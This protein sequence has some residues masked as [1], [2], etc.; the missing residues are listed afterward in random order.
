M[1]KRVSHDQISGIYAKEY[2]PGSGILHAAFMC[3]KRMLSILEPHDTRIARDL[4]EYVHTLD[5]MALK[6]T[7]QQY[8][9]LHPFEYNK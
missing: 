5:R 7:I 4:K 3:P 1:K 9:A 8:R 2:I 6:I